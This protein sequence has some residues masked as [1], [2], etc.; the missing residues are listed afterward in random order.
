MNILRKPQ[1]ALAVGLIS[2]I[3]LAFVFGGVSAPQIAQRLA[4]AAPAAIA[5]AGGGDQV[6]A[7]FTSPNGWPSRHP[8]LV[9]GEPLDETTRARI[10][11]AVADL[12]GVGGISWS[13]GDMMVEDH[14]NPLHCQEDVQ[15][16]LR[17]RTI[18]FEESSSRIDIASRSLLDEVAT[19][20]TPCVGAVIQISGHTDRSGPEEANIALSAERADAV[21]A[22]LV[23]RGI[24]SAA[25]RVE[26][27]GSSHPVEGLEPTD[28]ANRRIE[29]SV[30][31]TQ[32]L[33]PTPV[34]TPS[35]R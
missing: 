18:R 20:L 34:D 9:G 23:R 7:R 1:T 8:V 15:A 16:L 4:D 12:P 30:I 6:Q 22:A 19:A 33:M 31:S 10:A 32:P 14:F 11:R 17:A 35:A 29:F 26:G 25:L 24:P 5:Q 28:P 13:D 27:E 3:T 21:R 2:C